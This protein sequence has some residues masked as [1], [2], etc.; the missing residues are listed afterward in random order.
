MLRTHRQ[1]QAAG[2]EGEGCAG[3]QRGPG[4]PLTRGRSETCRSEKAVG[5]QLSGQ[6][7][8]ETHPG[9]GCPL[10]GRFRFMGRRMTFWGAGGA[11][12][13]GDSALPSGQAAR[14]LLLSGCFRALPIQVCGRTLSSKPR[15]SPP[16]H[17]EYLSPGLPVSILPLKENVT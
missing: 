9:R 7:Q 11:V 1:T 13:D 4:S 16:P 17:G 8:T 6:A 15:R 2:E 3:R 10:P 14:A 12:A 5:T